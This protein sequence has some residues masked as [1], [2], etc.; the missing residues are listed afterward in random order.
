MKWGERNEKQCAVAL[1]VYRRNFEKMNS[2]VCGRL[3]TVCNGCRWPPPSLPFSDSATLSFSLTL[4][5]FFKK[6]TFSASV[7]CFVSFTLL[8]QQQH[9]CRI[10]LAQ[11]VRPWSHNVFRRKAVEGQANNIGNHSFG[12]LCAWFLQTFLI[13]CSQI[14]AEKRMLPFQ[15]IITHG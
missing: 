5:P 14:W 13:P 6:Q 8:L 9:P 10:F 7:C 3:D 2:S 12:M 15:Y 1:G 11:R 4:P